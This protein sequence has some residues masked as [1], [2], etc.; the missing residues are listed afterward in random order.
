[1]AHCINITSPEYLALVSKTIIGQRELKARIATWQEINNTDKFPS[2][3][4]VEGLL[5]AKVI[6]Q[7]LPKRLVDLNKVF[8]GNLVEHISDGL[9]SM[10][11]NNKTDV[12]NSIIN[13]LN[14]LDN[15]IINHKDFTSNFFNAFNAISTISEKNIIFNSLPE[16]SR[17]ERLS[18]MYDDYLSYPEGFSGLNK[19]TLKVFRKMSS[20]SSAYLEN[21]SLLNAYIREY[22]NHQT[23]SETF[24]KDVRNYSKN[25]GR[26]VI[27]KD[28]KSDSEYAKEIDT[29][30][31][32]LYDTYEGRALVHTTERSDKSGKSYTVVY[33]NKPNP[34]NYFHESN[35]RKNIEKF[36]GNN[37][38]TTAREA[39][40]KI[41]KEFDSD[42]AKTLLK[43]LS[44]D[45]KILL[46]D[47]N[48]LPS[49]D[50]LFS[51]DNLKRAEALYSSD[52]NT[53]ILGK[54]GV[55]S[56]TIMHEIVHA[57]TNKYIHNNPNSKEVKDFTSIY[58]YAKK[59][60]KSD[61]YALSNI[62]EFIVGLFTDLKF[63]NKLKDIEA[64]TEVKEYKNLFHEL[65]SKIL[66]FFG[67]NTKQEKLLH[68]ALSVASHIITNNY[69][70]YQSLKEQESYYN[71]SVDQVIWNLA[72]PA[73]I[74]VDTSISRLN[75][76]YSPMEISE[77]S[78]ILAIR[79][80][81]LVDIH[82]EEN[83]LLSRQE[84]IDKVTPSNLFQELY[85]IFED[86]MYDLIDLNDP[87]KQPTID[88]LFKF[89][90]NYNDFAS[91]A[92]TSINFYEGLKFTADDNQSFTIN[93]KEELDSGISQSSDM[94]EEVDFHEE[95][96]LDGWMKNYKH[97]SVGES[98]TNK[99]KRALANIDEV[100]D[101]LDRQGN[102]IK[103]QG[104]L[105]YPKKL[106]MEIIKNDLLKS[107]QKVITSKHLLPALKI[108]ASEKTWALSL[109][110]TLEND[111]ELLSQF[112]SGMKKDFTLHSI[113]ST[114]ENSEGVVSYKTP[115]INLTDDTNVWISN[116]RSILEHRVSNNFRY[117]VYNSD[118]TLNAKNIKNNIKI[119]QDLIKD[120]NSIK[121]SGD[122]KE[123]KKFVTNK[124]I[125]VWNQLRA[126]GI[127][128]SENDV[129]NL[130]S[131][132][133]VDTELI[134]DKFGVNKNSFNLDTILDKLIKQNS[135]AE[136]NINKD[137]LS[138]ISDNRSNYNAIAILLVNTTE[139]LVEGSVH[140]NGKSYYT[141]LQPSYL[142]KTIKQLKN[143]RENK[144]EFED[145]IKEQFGQYLGTIANEDGTYNISWINDITDKY[146]GNK[147]R[148]L[149]EHK[150]VL[151][152]N[153]TD[154]DSL[155]SQDYMNMLLVE[156]FSGEDTA[157][158]HVPILA[159]APSAEFIKFNKVTTNYKN[160]I[161][162]ELANNLFAYEYNRIKV[163]RARKEGIADGSI[164]AIKNFDTRGDSFVFLDFLNDYLPT[165]DK[166]IS[167]N[168]NEISSTELMNFITDKIK[169]HLDI[170]SE[171][172]IENLRKLGLLETNDSGKYL[173][174]DS[175][176]INKD[177]MQEKLSEYF[178]NS[179][180][181]TA[182]VIQITSTDLSYFSNVEDFQKRNKQIHAPGNMINT[183]ASYKGERLG[184]DFE[185]YLVIKDYEEN[186]S[187]TVYE[188]MKEALDDNK[189]ISKAD[190]E[191]ILSHYKNSK[192]AN[193][194]T[195]AQAYRT[196]ESARSIIAMNTGWND[197]LEASYQ[198]LNKGEWSMEDY[199]TIW[200]AFKPFVYTQ[201]ARDSGVAS[202]RD[203][204]TNML[205]KVPTQHKNSETILLPIMKK[206][207]KSV[208]I[209]G[210]LKA[211]QDHELDVIMFDS[212]VKVGLQGVLDINNFETSK[213]IV[214]Y[215]G[216]FK[217]DSQVFKTVSYEDYKIQQPI[218]EHL[219][220]AEQLFG[221]QLRKL[222]L[223]DIS[224]DSDLK[225]N[226]RGKEFNKKDFVQLVDNLIIENIIEPYETLKNDFKDKDRLLGII[227]EELISNTRY[228]RDLFN[229]LQVD[230]KGELILPF[231][232]PSQS[233]RIQQL[234]NS[235]WKSRIT[236]QKIK[237]GKAV[238]V[239]SYGLSDNLELKYKRIN[240]KIS[241]D[242]MEV[243]LPFWSN[244]IP[245][246]LDSFEKDGI[247][248][249][250][251]MLDKGIIDEEFLEGIAYRIPTEDKYSMWPIKVKGFY[252]RNSGG[253]I[254][255]PKEITTITGSD[256]D[257]DSMY[258]M[259]KEFIVKK[260]Y[261]IKS[262]WNSFYSSHPDLHEQIKDVY[263]DIDKQNSIWKSLEKTFNKTDGLFIDEDIKATK[264]QA[265]KDLG[266]T[267]KFS[268]WFNENK[269]AF[270][271]NDYFSTIVPDMSKDP[272]EM[273]R[274]E[275]NNL[276]ISSIQAVLQN[277]DTLVKQLNPGNFEGP[278]K[279]AR[280][281]NILSSGEYTSFEELNKLSLEEL[282]KISNRDALDILDYSS[283]IAL[284]NQNMTAAKL[285]GIIANH[286]TNH[287]VR[288]R[289]DIELKDITITKEINGESKSFTYP[290][291]K[292]D[293]KSY[294][295]L[296]SILTPEGDSYISK[297]YASFLAASVDAVK[298]PV[299][300]FFNLNTFTADSAMLLTGLGYDFDSIGLLL[301]Q[302]IIEQL[303]VEYDRGVKKGI[304][305]K[306]AVNKLLEKYR[307]ILENDLNTPIGSGI[308]EAL[309]ND[310][311]KERLG[312]MIAMNKRIQDINNSEKREELI[313][314]NFG[315]IQDFYKYQYQ[316]LLN[317][318]NILDSAQELSDFV[319][320]TRAD[321]SS[322]GAGPYIA[323]TVYKLR[324]VNK[325]KENID[326]KN[327][328]LK[329][330][331][332]INLLDKNTV[333]N[334]EELRK[335]LRNSDLGFIQAFTT[336]GLQATRYAMEEYFPH[337]SEYYSY[338]FDIIESYGTKSGNLSVKNMNKIYSEFF[339][340]Y[341]S[342]F[343]SFS[344]DNTSKYINDF[345]MEFVK[346]T[347]KHPELK[348]LQFIKNINYVNPNDK[349]P[350]AS[351][352]F[353]G[354]GKLSSNVRDSIIREWESLIYHPEYRE[355]ALELF[356]YNYYVNGFSFGATSFMHLA[357]V[358]VKLQIEDYSKNLFDISKTTFTEDSLD[359]FI[360]Q[361]FRNHLGDK[362]FVPKVDSINVKSL[363]NKEG[364][365]LETFEFKANKYINSDMFNISDNMLMYIEVE[366]EGKS[367]YYK[368][369][370]EEDITTLKR[371]YPLGLR[372]NSLE[373]S[374]DV[375]ELGT[376]I[377]T[378]QSKVLIK[379]DWNP[380][381]INMP[382]DA[383]DYNYDNDP[384][385]QDMSEEQNRL[386]NEAQAS[387]L[388]EVGEDIIEESK[389]KCK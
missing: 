177:N 91:V 316:V 60:I 148:N 13:S 315:D 101:K 63:Q 145:Y 233:D 26:V 357:P 184:K 253:N 53:I 33:V 349:K 29:H 328:S 36:F 212:A 97:S 389:N 171:K 382:Q 10:I 116:W 288:Q 374:F 223:S 139:D 297:R 293:G 352:E 287:A 274:R 301:R 87:S 57:L 104:I 50:Y 146:V 284:H 300:S 318:K 286:S 94:A 191:F 123:R 383:Y 214:D 368:T 324:K 65:L 235:I 74:E 222:F 278:K 378:E 175:L 314:S 221:T 220:D 236:K 136:S 44:F 82:Q 186:S 133:Y 192:G 73:P 246:G 231:Y 302:P 62:D 255:M 117:S 164:K 150:V 163:I 20:L 14:F 334:T 165:I 332:V 195:D 247:L 67:I 232:D 203:P 159:E 333:L 141:Y 168:N 210:L 167:D 170:K 295:S 126:I 384:A 78:D 356:K 348:D 112:Y 85:E 201:N 5:S 337:Y 162:S 380:I 310:Y 93:N 250:Q 285:I 226:L 347:N 188:L 306:N 89:I 219:Q 218:P 270:Y 17:Y 319:S 4:E 7:Y 264:R 30:K 385:Y 106:N 228:S 330:A 217:E 42:I 242:Y 296:H 331:D 107:M 187:D 79:F 249:V 77:L 39:L 130:L 152:F 194:I 169:E 135:W 355:F 279:T 370:T 299:L 6:D 196:L 298:D 292:L 113:V 379:T 322:G 76:Q 229:A 2:I 119:L 18:E 160:N 41:I 372:D 261:D 118:G 282:D 342:Q 66:E 206:Q 344:N 258:L 243:Y 248:D 358:A 257:I 180:L 172:A 55:N 103:V 265:R 283:Q 199:N 215:I 1:M 114:V 157:W 251:E 72:S 271:L 350:I 144:K 52:S 245:Q 125:T 182:N 237:G 161:A 252:P 151:N 291:F 326:K 238:Q 294:K 280:I 362:Q 153:K 260:K 102:P 240:G 45:V 122:T 254:I 325:H 259:L 386:Y 51:I 174:L 70:Y 366:H 84:V 307:N 267:E 376:K 281:L 46:S 88:N 230:E 321:T 313:Q 40:E 339:A 138:L 80:S 312:E 81:E 149:L 340:Y 158:Y 262:A 183:L 121:N 59:Q 16:G 335:E 387:L 129:K 19:T 209:N 303:I 193:N 8:K 92:T 204:E 361:F 64:T 124:K 27:Y 189:I 110:N 28:N 269:D 34:K 329:N 308:T 69:N 43:N 353:R 304:N 115:T 227:K 178:Y 95:S 336:V 367:A 127:S 373:Y 35:N 205:L 268:E 225:I 369:F 360:D 156:Y 241:I 47:D 142:S 23:T 32:D 200:Q 120:W 3:E 345:P 354:G 239:S 266:I 83:P 275:R 343:E 273:D 277:P 365:F 56:N 61:D 86:D 256:F 371:V 338:I 96:I 213:E 98:L 377:D 309:S 147:N 25:Q 346:F 327:S 21:S 68:Q 22:L 244:T 211:M 190:K 197:K 12:F 198:R 234:L 49:S 341:M 381:D 323:N 263:K 105:G 71:S 75:K 388:R 140:E 320:A 128:V 305:K 351:L 363:L 111:N 276:L 173:Y 108:L 166:I 179:Y 15:N 100:T 109:V 99:L 207:Y 364:N 208:K 58:E 24:S 54:L 37:T 311:T 9:S 185:N 317:Y 134:A 216:S 176:G 48:Y 289:T 143:I 11:F 155:S 224:D 137:A 31:K 202:A 290:R 132:A 272:S 131:D 38:E 154:Y 90:N 359:I 375:S 181:A